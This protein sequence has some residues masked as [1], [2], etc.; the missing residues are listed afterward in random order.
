M[1]VFRKQRLVFL[2]T[3]KTGSTA[4]EAVLGDQADLAITKAPELKHTP[5]GRYNRFLAPYLKAALG[6]DGFETCAL[7]RE[8]AD[9][10]GSWYRYRQRDGVAPN[11]STRGISFA[12]FVRAYAAEKRPGFAQVGS[13]AQMVQ[14]KDGARVTHLFRYEDMPAFVKFLQERLGQSITL[15]RLNVSPN[16]QTRLGAAEQD[17]LRD[18]LAEDYAIYDSLSPKCTEPLV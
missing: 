10:L 13:Q 15:P 9:W 4:V 6:E 16:G 18:A 1:L 8:P 7:I 12:D 3:P 11:R 17:L 14:T 5:L 2:A